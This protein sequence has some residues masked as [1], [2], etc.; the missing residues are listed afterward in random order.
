MPSATSSDRDAAPDADVVAPDT[1][2]ALLAGVLDGS[3]AGIMA[4]VAVRNSAGTIID[5]E[6]LVTNRA[7]EAIIGRRHADLLGRRL[8]EETPGAA[9]AGLFARYVQV[10]ETREPA[11]FEQHYTFERVDAWFQIGVQPF[12]D[13]FVVSF[14]DVTE[15][16]R[17]EQRLRDGIGVLD[18]YF[19]L[20]IGLIC[21]ADVN[22][23]FR[24]LNPGW[25]RTLGWTNQELL[26][27]PFIEFVHPDD[28]AETLAAAAELAT[29]SRLVRFENRYR[30][31]DGGYRTLAW[32]VVGDADR[33]LLFAL[34]HDITADQATTR[35]LI[36]AR[37]AATEALAQR[38]QFVSNMSHEIR[39]PLN[40]V[41]GIAE[42]L[43]DT[44]LDG[45]QQAW[46]SL[47]RDAGQQLLM[48][49]NDVQEFSRLERG[50]LRLQRQP[51]DVRTFVCGVVDLFA[52]AAADKGL[53]LIVEVDDSAPAVAG[54]DPTRLR[55]VLTNLVGNAIRFT[56]S[57]S[58]TLAVDGVGD[59]EPALRFAVRDTGVGIRPRDQR[60]IFEAFVQV[61]SAD[62]REFAGTGM[63]L[64]IAEE[65][66]ERMGGTLE[67]SSVAGQGSTFR[68]VV[69]L[70]RASPARAGAARF[71][72][73]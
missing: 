38:S 20:D 31:K 52:A 72:S 10:V 12:G 54:V 61:D 47:M 33:G 24:R 26:S 41:L 73:G 6:W 60:R 64:T 23:M 67:L 13:G 56:P 42:L 2:A 39:A 51:T 53:E 18:Q 63:G 19:T 43:A 70:E 44:P 21:L 28:R 14:I 49:L 7:A 59:D 48:I 69:P 15:T 22:G 37:D 71:P 29:G 62:A 27:R 34:A 58:V 65:L 55:Q 35:E 5:F 30:C 16:K 4:F 36:A 3:L 40:G 8:L 32:S 45:Q 11:T 25:N 17:I 68:V 46:V 57:G 66:V 1:S 50:Q 9:E